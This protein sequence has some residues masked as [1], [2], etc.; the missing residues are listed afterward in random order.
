MLDIDEK[1]S[2]KKL[3]EKLYFIN[4]FLHFKNL[5]INKKKTKHGWHIC[6]RI[7]ST[8]KLSDFDIIFLQSILGDD[9]KRCMF[10]WLRVRSGCKKWNVLYKQKFDKNMRLISHEQQTESCR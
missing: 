5:D 7:N 9:W 2:E 8:R 6:I 1:L 10:N 3:I 4:K